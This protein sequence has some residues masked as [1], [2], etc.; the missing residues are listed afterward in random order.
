MSIKLHP[1][2]YVSFIE[3]DPVINTIQVDTCRIVLSPS[4]TDTIKLHPELYAVVIEPDPVQVK[5]PLDTIRHIIATHT[6][7]ADTRR[8]I[9]FPR[10]TETLTVNLKRFVTN[11]E[12]VTEDMLLCI[13]R[14]TAAFLDMVRYI[15]RKARFRTIVTRHVIKQERILI[16]TSIRVPVVIAFY[17]ET[18]KVRSIRRAQSLAPM[19]ESSSYE[20]PLH[21]FSVYGIRSFSFT[22]GE[23]TLGDSFQAEVIYPLAIDQL[24]QGMF[25]DFSF[26]FRVEE[27]RQKDL[28]QTVRG[29]YDKDAMLYM[30]INTPEKKKKSGRGNSRNHDIEGVDIKANSME[31]EDNTGVKAS[32]YMTDIAKGLS[33]HFSSNFEDFT[34]ANDY[35]NSNMTYQDFISALFGWTTRLP[36][37]Q[38]NV[39]IRGNALCAV[40]RGMEKKVID[41][42]GWHYTTP[43]ITKRLVRSIWTS[44]DN[45][46]GGEATSE[47]TKFSKPFSGMIIFKNT[48][49]KYSKGFLVEEWHNLNAYE[50]ENFP[51]F[52]TE[53]LSGELI[54]GATCTIY[55]YR[56]DGYLEEKKLWNYSTGD[57][58]RTTYDYS[59]VGDDIYLS[60][61][62]EINVKRYE[63]ST[64]NPIPGSVWDLDWEPTED[65]KKVHTTRTVRETLHIPIGGGWYG[66]EVYV[67]GGF[68]GS[69]LSQGKPGNRTSQYMIEQSNRSLSGHRSYSEGVPYASLINT[70]FP[71]KGT[72]FLKKLTEAIA[73]LNRKTEE[74]VHLELVLPIENGVPQEKH[75][76]DFDE[77]VRFRDNIYFLVSNSVQLT[78]TSLKQTLEIVRWY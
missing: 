2:L 21:G 67:N 3:P 6:I 27:V 43:T 15:G 19:T 52:S 5:E 78:P 17:P 51:I 54:R 49:L 77:Q 22:L 75:I 25:L 53:M 57:A 58:S 65:E 68:E 28:I 44:G 56:S 35:S 60:R 16:D 31:Y 38:I 29:M 50:V 23:R 36:Q 70:E 42:T 73:W 72:A 40:Q 37:R 64:H 74:R 71:V 48:L 26:A 46:M 39:F 11:K 34:L 33:M 18:K 62:L 13:G 20:N 76:I 9:F 30:P 12:I 61:E 47:D 41:V 63:G 69:S 1:E 4:Y 66:T 8:T 32:T 24:V 59:G 7:K 14:K 55:N 45:D 10:H